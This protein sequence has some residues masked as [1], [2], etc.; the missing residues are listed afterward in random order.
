MTSSSK[1]IVKKD[2]CVLEEKLSRNLVE[3]DNITLVLS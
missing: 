3:E 1:V 2:I